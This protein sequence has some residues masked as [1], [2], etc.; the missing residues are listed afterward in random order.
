MARGVRRQK[1]RPPEC[2]GRPTVNA[3]KCLRL[4]NNLANGTY[5]EL[6]DLIAGIGAYFVVKFTTIVVNSITKRWIFQY[7]I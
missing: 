7:M 4:D 3:G 1:K 6:R 2:I 5:L